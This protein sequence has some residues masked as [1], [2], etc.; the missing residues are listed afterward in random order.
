MGPLDHWA[1]GQKSM[2][3]LG[4]ELSAAEAEQ[5]V[6]ACPEW[7]VR[8][9]FAHQAGVAADLLAGRLDGVAT[10][11]WTQRQVAER[12]DRSLPQI[13]DEWDADAPQLLA[14][15]APFGD[16]VDPRLV[17]D[18]WTHH[19]DVRGAVGRAGDRDTDLARWAAVGL[20]R[21]AQKQFRTAGLDPSSVAF[22]EDGAAPDG[23]AVVVDRFEFSRA[24]VGR[25]SRAQVRSWAWTV[26]DPEPYL[27]LV[28][29]FAARPDDLEE[30]A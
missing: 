8:E 11:P 19:Q 18:L 5:V 16:D 1:S 23:V 4:R 3:A 24:A 12:A 15:L 26:A 27:P 21:F 22:T 29:V 10:D 17:V 13:L 9:V 2:S 14:T 28:A 30:P 25:R 6:P 20:R 7:T